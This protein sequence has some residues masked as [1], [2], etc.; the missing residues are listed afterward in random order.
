MEKVRAVPQRS[1]RLAMVHKELIAD[2]CL[3]LTGTLKHLGTV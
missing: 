1:R 3:S 2:L